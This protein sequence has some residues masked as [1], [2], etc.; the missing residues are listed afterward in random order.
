MRQ[1][2]WAQEP[3]PALGS[4]V[5]TLGH[6]TLSTPPDLT[7]A[8]LQLHTRVMQDEPPGVDDE[9]VERLLLTFEELTSNGLRHGRSPVA[10]TVTITA[11]GWLVDV[12]DAATDRCPTPAVD[13][14][15]AHGG[16]GLYLVARLSPAHGWSVQRGRKHV[17]A[18]IRRMVAPPPPRSAG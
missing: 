6:W 9:D 17:W 8:R 1:E 10:A 11:E 14:D 7:A 5:S 13:R 16:L 2:L 4:D 18:H 15:P 12:T 3:P